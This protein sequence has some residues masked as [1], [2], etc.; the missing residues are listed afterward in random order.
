MSET[1]KPKEPFEKSSRVSYSLP[2]SLIERL[3]LEA[4]KSERPVSTE[5]KRRLEWS[6]KRDAK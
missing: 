5:V 6:F 1:P 4:G 3:K 2:P